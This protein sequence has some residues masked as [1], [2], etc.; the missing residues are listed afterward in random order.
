MKPPTPW[1]EPPYPQSRSHVRLVASRLPL[2]LPMNKSPVLVLHLKGE[3]FDQIKAGEKTEEY[4]LRT[5]YWKTRLENRVYSR[6]DLFRG[7]P[8]HAERAKCLTLPWRGGS[9]KTITHPHFGPDP[10]EVYAINVRC[11]DIPNA[12]K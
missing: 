3:Y 10:V 1:I 11:D 5:P 6:I 4:R 8:K 9:V 7:Y 2:A 12:I